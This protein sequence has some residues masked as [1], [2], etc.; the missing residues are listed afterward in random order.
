MEEKFDDSGKYVKHNVDYLNDISDLKEDII[1]F[2]QF[3]KDDSKKY[4]KKSIN[5]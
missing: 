4:L 2:I 3:L 1:E 5:Y